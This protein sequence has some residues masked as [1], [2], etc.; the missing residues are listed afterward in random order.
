MGELF[1]GGMRNRRAVLGDEY[2]DRS[3]ARATAL[4]QPLQDLITEFCWGGVW[5]RDAL[6]RP[7]RSLI[8]IAMLMAGGHLEELATHVRGALRNGCT[9]AEITEVVIHGSIYCGVPSSL[10]AMRVVQTVLETEG[11]APAPA[12]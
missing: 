3:L 2:V 11:V 4:T 1:D 8:T 5:G 7:T 9:P 10:S 6:P 12:G